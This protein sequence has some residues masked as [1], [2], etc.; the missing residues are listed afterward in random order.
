MG[1]GLSEGH[2]NAACIYDA[3]V[4][5]LAVK[6]HVSVA[7]DDHYGLE[8]FEDREKAVIGS[9]ASEDVGFVLWGGVAKQDGAEAGDF[10][11]AV[12]WQQKALE[13]P[14]YV[15]S[16]GAIARQCLKW[17]APRNLVQQLW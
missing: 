13:F 7:A 12:H 3:G 9:Q 10:K 4:A 16:S 8:F 1:A 15:K 17:S 11:E 2:A 5:N 6:L 14:E